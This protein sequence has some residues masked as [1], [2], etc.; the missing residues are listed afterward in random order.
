MK[1]IGRCTSCGS[2]NLIKS[3]RN[4]VLGYSIKCGDCGSMASVIK[5]RNIELVSVDNGKISDGYHTFDELYFHRK[6]LFRFVTKM[7]PSNSWKSKAHHDGSMYPNYFIVGVSTPMGDYTYHYHLDYWDDFD[8]KILDR[9]PMYDGHKPSDIDRIF[10][11][12]K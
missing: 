3:D 4:T 9:A 6:E 10:T 11:L 5:P 1:L 2:E 12:I 8:V 7:F